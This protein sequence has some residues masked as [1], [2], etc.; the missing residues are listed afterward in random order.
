[1]RRTAIS[2]RDFLLR[3]AAALSAPQALSSALAAAAPGFFHAYV[4]TY[5][6]NGGGIYLFRIERGSA[7]LM[8]MQVVDDIRNPSWLALNPAQ[9]RLY[10][11][12]EID[13]YKGTKDGAVVCYAIDPASLQLTRIGAV[14]S[15]GAAPAH[16]SVHPSG[17]FVFV[18]NYGGGNVAVFPVAA[19][20]TLGEATDVRPSVGPRHHARAIDDPP[21]QFA[22]SDHDGP[23]VHMVAA[24]PTGQF[25][26]ANDA[27]LDLTLIWRL[28]AQAGRL[29]PADAPVL[30]APSGSAPRHFAFHPN[31]KFFY[32]L[33]EHD[34]KVAVYDYDGSRG[35]MRLKQSLSTLPPHF[36]G[37][38]LAS[39]ILIAPNGRF[40]YV[41]NRLHSTIALFAIAED[42]QLRAVSEAWTH[43]DSPRSL[44][45]DASGQL[46]F[47]CN[48]RSDSITSFRVNPATG[49]LAFTGRYEPVGSPAVMVM[50]QPR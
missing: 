28:D 41:S 30:I 35:A 47:S 26:I 39:E 43:A 27:G 7:A 22:V 23:H 29:L 12:S 21:G 42:G 6:P 45:M 25:V 10:A 34:A 44:A 32:N 8:Q 13:N 4:G 3:A 24:D 33:Y 36:A 15:A 2:R 5:T 37:S 18:A 31:G 17:K 9:T 16:L 48:Q 38:N 20:G 50:I 19:D 40:L 46:L 14:S 11:I 49:G 1:M